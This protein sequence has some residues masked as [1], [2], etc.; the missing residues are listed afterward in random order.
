MVSGKVITKGPKEGRLFLLPFSN[1]RTLPFAC[2]IVNNQSEVW[3]KRL[4]QTNSK[5]LSHLFQHGFHEN[6]YKTYELVN[7][8]SPCTSLIQLHNSTFL[9]LVAHTK[10]QNTCKPGNNAQLSAMSMKSSSQGNGNMSWIPDFG[11]S[12]HVTMKAKISNSFFILMVQIKIFIGNGEGLSICEDFSSFV[13]PHD[14]HITPQLNNLLHVPSITKN[15][16]SVSQSAKDNFVFFEFDSD[17][18]LIISQGMN[19]VNLRGITGVDGLYSFNNLQLQSHSP[20]LQSSPKSLSCS[21]I[22][23]SLLR[24]VK[25]KL[26]QIRHILVTCLLYIIISICGI[27]DLVIQTVM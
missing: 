27:I 7:F 25:L 6:K 14:S 21:T 22:T 17:K 11:A 18:C 15:S 4:V 19:K 12:F 8:M 23:S 2:S 20:Q 26:V 5:I 3:H 16:L 1:L 13:S 24:S 9:I 10:P